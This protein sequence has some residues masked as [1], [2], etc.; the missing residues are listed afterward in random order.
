MKKLMLITLLVGFS[1]YFFGQPEFDGKPG[2]E[3]KEKIEAL[4]RSFISQELSLSVS[5]SEKFWPV[6][7]ENE[8]K[9]DEL[10][11]E[12]HQHMKVLKA[13]GMKDDEIMNHVTQI[14]NIRKAEID[15]ELELIQSSVSILG[16]Q[17]A[18]KLPVIE[19]EFHHM[20]AEKFKDNHHKKDDNHDKGKLRN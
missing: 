20:L 10:K 14:S 6:Y 16:A 7:N 3:K 18:S 19:R 8:K 5:E 13:G 11:K 17:R 12:M 1:N 4:K 15:L 2:G 9:K